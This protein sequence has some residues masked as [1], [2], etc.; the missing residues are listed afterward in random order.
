VETG[1]A[2]IHIPLRDFLLEHRNLLGK[3][4]AMANTEDTP[5]RRWARA[6]FTTSFLYPLMVSRAVSCPSS[7]SGRD[8]GH[9][10]DIVWFSF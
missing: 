6:N 1:V 7:S 9:T 5:Y 8:C 2:G 10:P 4:S 3:T